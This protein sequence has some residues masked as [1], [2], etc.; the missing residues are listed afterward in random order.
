VI[1]CGYDENYLTIG[2]LGMS[3]MGLAI[4]ELN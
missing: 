1:D 3:G 4:D 2:W